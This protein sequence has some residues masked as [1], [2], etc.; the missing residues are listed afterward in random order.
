MAY[1]PTRSIVAIALEKGGGFLSPISKV[2]IIDDDESVRR[3]L[4]R[5]FRTLKCEPFLY[6]SAEQ[7]LREAPAAGVDLIMVDIHLP[8]MSGIEMVGCLAKLSVKGIPI[9]MTAHTDY[10]ISQ[11]T[12]LRKPFTKQQLLSAILLHTNAPLGI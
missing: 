12:C 6:G 11:S 9:L 1:G 5:L 7:F 2:A 8:G 4:A 10:E 3:S